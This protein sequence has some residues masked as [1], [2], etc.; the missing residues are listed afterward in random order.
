MKPYI[1]IISAVLTTMIF[2]SAFTSVNATE[3][4]DKISFYLQGDINQDER[5]N[6]KDVTALQKHIAN[7]SSNEIVSLETADFNCDGDVNVNDVT[8][9]QK[10]ALWAKYKGAPDRN[11]I[12]CDRSK[13]YQISTD[14]KIESQLILEEANLGK[15]SLADKA[16]WLFVALVTS[17]EEFRSLTKT[18]SPDFDD[19]FFENNA[20]IYMYI[21]GDAWNYGYEIPFVGVEDNTLIVAPRE[22]YRG[23]PVD[24]QENGNGFEMIIPEWYIFTKVSKADIK[25]VDKI[26]CTYY[27]IDTES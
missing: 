2:I 4:T 27:N 8:E 25:S 18:Y 22:Y 20:L 9:I 6:I 11:Y 21:L 26:V 17:K 14:T 10:Y 12:Y 7:I 24:G 19:K 23:G 1:K 3:G 15:M 16:D 13:N 5:I